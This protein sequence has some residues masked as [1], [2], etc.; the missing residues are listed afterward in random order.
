[1]NQSQE[2]VLSYLTGYNNIDSTPVEAL[3]KLVEEDPYFSVA[4]FLLAAKLK[5]ENDRNFSAQVQKTTV[6]FSNSFWLDYQLNAA[7]ALSFEGENPAVNSSNSR[8]ATDSFAVN[9]VDDSPTEPVIAPDSFKTV[10][11][12]TSDVEPRLTEEVEQTAVIVG[13]TEAQFETTPDELDK[14]I[15]ASLFAQDEQVLAPET[16]VSSSIDEM[17][18]AETTP[19]T[20]QEIALP[21]ETTNDEEANQP[22]E[23]AAAISRD[24][25]PQA[26]QFLDQLDQN[27]DAILHTNPENTI[28]DAPASA[29]IEVVEVEEEM[30][31][32][33]HGSDKTTEAFL[34]SVEPVPLEPEEAVEE[35]PDDTDF[36]KQDIPPQEKNKEELLQDEHER[37]FLNIKAMLDASSQEANAETKEAYVPIDPYYTIDYFASQ[38]IKLD[39]DQNPNDQLGRNLKKFTQW[40]KHMKKLG[41]ED[42][43]ETLKSTETEADIQQIADSSNIIKEVVTEAMASVLEKQGKKGKAIELYNKLSF[44]NPDKSS[45]FADK[46]KNLK[47]I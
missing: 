23:E 32:V 38:G 31:G 26:T 7:S 6:F 39:L 19:S 27:V 43:L 29:A 36:P 4:H 28:T 30:A 17:E 18:Q 37:M 46:I 21:P 5:A 12:D 40:L 34:Q 22:E 44:L 13:V 9:N 15:E 33:T 47:G 1:M 8:D 24:V 16:L 2:K 14:N 45:Y 11:E 41:P 10:Q 20:A 3:Q 42:A 35:D 25:D